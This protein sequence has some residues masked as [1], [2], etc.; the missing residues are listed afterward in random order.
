MAN[1]KTK[2]NHNYQKI[3]LY[4]SPKTKE[5]KKKHPCR[6]V[7]GAQI[8]TEWRELMARWWLE[9]WARQWLVEWAVPHLCVNKLGGTTGKRD[10][11]CNPGFQ[12]QK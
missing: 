3:K 8:G 11:L 9:H 4:G 5:L 6:Q 10:K 7:G 1:I 2:N 12:H